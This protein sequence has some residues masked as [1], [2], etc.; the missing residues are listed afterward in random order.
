M[1]TTLPMFAMTL[2]IAFI[3][4]LKNMTFFERYKLFLYELDNMCF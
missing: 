1:H 4:N 2:C 3:G